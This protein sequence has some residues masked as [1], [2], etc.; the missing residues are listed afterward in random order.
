MK[1]PVLSVSRITRRF[2]SLIAVNKVSFE[3]EEGTITS[4]IGPNGAGKSTIFNLLTGYLP[5]SEGRA[6]FL[7]RRIDRL[8]TQKIAELGI[9]RAYQIARPF[10]GLSVHDNVKVGALFGRVGPRDVDAVVADA[11]ALAG[12]DRLASRPASDLTIGQLRKLELAR[13]VAARPAL[14]LADEPL[15]GL[16]PTESE[17]ILASFRTLVARGM[18][19]LLVEHDMV[20]VMKVSDRVVVLDAGELIAEGSPTEVVRDPRVIEAYLGQEHSAG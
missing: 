12:L 11:L 5:L 1:P 3:V 19:V 14:L 13:A 7:G 9:A 15:A 18:T 20:S 17:E 16:V 10:R 6:D 2:G 4:L 8:A